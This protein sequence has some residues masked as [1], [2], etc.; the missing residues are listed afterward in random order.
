MTVTSEVENSK[1]EL[2]I[3]LC[4]HVNF[5]PHT[6]ADDIGLH[7]TRYHGFKSNSAWPASNS[8][9]VRLK[10]IKQADQWCKNFAFLVIK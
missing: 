2:I 3:I 4:S 8:N 6:S 1:N 7:D 9:W 10:V 5:P